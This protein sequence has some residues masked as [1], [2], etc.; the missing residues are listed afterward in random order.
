M[1]LNKAPLTTLIGVNLMKEKTGFLTVFYNA[2][3]SMSVQNFNE[4]K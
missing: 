1:F 2:R 4:P 3:H